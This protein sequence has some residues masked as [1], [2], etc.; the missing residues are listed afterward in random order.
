MVVKTKCFC[1]AVRIMTRRVIVLL[2]THEIETSLHDA[3]RLQIILKRIVA[4][5]S[6][7]PLAI[8]MLGSLTDDENVRI[9]N[10]THTNIG[11]LGWH[12]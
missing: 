8:I 4:A 6:V 5:L 11:V 1:V 9:L 7:N 10:V 3:R 2:S 12:E